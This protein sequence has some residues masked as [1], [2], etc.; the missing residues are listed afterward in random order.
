MQMQLQHLREQ[1]IART[2]RDPIADPEPSTLPELKSG[3]FD[4]L[5]VK[6]EF[7]RIHSFLNI[8]LHSEYKNYQL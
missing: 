8:V 5:S 6:N 4:R 3:S 7:W 2:G 1:L